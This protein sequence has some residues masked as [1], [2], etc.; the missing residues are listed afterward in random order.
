MCVCEQGPSARSVML[1]TI[2]RSPMERR[3]CA[4]M[5]MIDLKAKEKRKT[6]LFFA[7]TFRPPPTPP[8]QNFA[9][10]GPYEVAKKPSPPPP[11]FLK[12]HP[13]LGVREGKG[14]NPPQETPI[15]K[16][17]ARFRNTSALLTGTPVVR[18]GR[19][20]LQPVFHNNKVAQR[21]AGEQVR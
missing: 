21:G 8:K 5:N 15:L 20:K 7:S 1:A 12:Q 4:N 13:F 17:P 14:G 9:K 11:A 3:P 19:P 6:Q 10:I 2:S 18:T 16:E